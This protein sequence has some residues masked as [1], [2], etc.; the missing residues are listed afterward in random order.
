MSRALVLLLSA[1]HLR[2][3]LGSRGGQRSRRTA[4]ALRSTCTREA[5]AAGRQVATRAAQRSDCAAALAAHI[6]LASMSVVASALNRAISPGRFSPPIVSMASIRLTA[7]RL[8]FAMRGSP[9]GLKSMP[10]RVS[11]RVVSCSRIVEPITK[12]IANTA[13]V[14][15]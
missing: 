6:T 2:V 15:L 14:H 11:P 4:R 7:R 9:E 5:G 13:A 12:R 8:V 10:T 1:T 3:G